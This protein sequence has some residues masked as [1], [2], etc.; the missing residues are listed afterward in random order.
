MTL[1]TDKSNVT[2]DGQWA[3]VTEY[4]YP[5]SLSDIP[6]GT[7][8]DVPKYTTR[9]DDWIGRDTSTV[10]PVTNFSSVEDAGNQITTSTITSPHR[11][12]R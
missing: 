8:Q 1:S 12:V 2:S 9:T 3:A 10:A 11:T 4:N 5:R 6:G 7:L